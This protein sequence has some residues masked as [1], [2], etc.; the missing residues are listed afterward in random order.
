MRGRAPAVEA[1]RGRWEIRP[2]GLAPGPPSS[3]GVPQGS[4]PDGGGHVRRW[5]GEEMGAAAGAGAGACEFGECSPIPRWGMCTGGEGAVARAGSRAGGESAGRPPVWLRFAGLVVL[6]VGTS[7]MTM[8]PAAASPQRSGASRGGVC[9][10]GFQGLSSLERGP[11]AAAPGHSALRLRGG[12]AGSQATMEHKVPPNGVKSK[13]YTQ[14]ASASLNGGVEA[15]EGVPPLNGDD[16]EKKI[17]LQVDELKLEALRKLGRSLRL[18]GP[19]TARRKYKAVRKA[20]KTDDL[21]YQNS[22][23]KAGVNPVGEIETVEVH[24]EDG[25]IWTFN[26]PKLLSNQQA[27][28]FCVQGR[29]EER[30]PSEAEMRARAFDQLSDIEKLRQLAQAELPAGAAGVA[31]AAAQGAA[32]EAAGHAC[33][34]TVAGEKGSPEDMLA[35]KEEE[36]VGG[37]DAEVEVQEVGHTDEEGGVHDVQDAS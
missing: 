11:A 3:A 10:R 1:G 26:N 9:T 29:Y 19:G 33:D 18:G 34:D 12:D 28:Q 35:E 24:K 30:K 23:R 22:R 14:V 4:P 6:I 36:E 32:A 21:K 37:A 15:D 27:N 7:A 8:T 5:Q 16:G 13:S 31:A 20:G 17:V 2:L 25:T